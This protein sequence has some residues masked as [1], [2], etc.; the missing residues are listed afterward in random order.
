MIKERK[1]WQGIVA[2]LA[3]FALSIETSCSSFWSK[4]SI[5]THLWNV[6]NALSA[7]TQWALPAIVM[8][9]GSIFLASS[10][11]LGLRILWKSYIPF[12]TISAVL[13]WLATAVVW[14]QNNHPQELDFLT[15]R[16]CMSEVLDSPGNIGFCH[17]LVTFFILYPLL[18][19][20]AASRKLTIY[21]MVLFYAM[22]LIESVFKDIPYLSVLALFTDQLNWGYYRA[23][24]FY[25]LCGVW[26]TKY[27]H[28][29]KLC[30]SIYS[31]GILATGA[32]VALTSVATGFSPGY[33]NEYIGYSSPF[34]GLQ[35]VAVFLFIKRLCSNRHAPIFARLTR[36][37]WYCIPVLFVSSFFSD[38]LTA[39]FSGD[40]L[41]D[42]IATSM[43][44]AIIAALVMILFGFLPGFRIL[45]GDYSY[46]GGNTL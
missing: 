31:A 24:T 37:F 45:V 25:L 38:R 41:L 8:L 18:S 20:I 43:T 21:G 14:M 30:L 35:T 13:W 22:G 27:D 28:D 7:L 5:G 29:W 40:S 23:W 19:R 3:I 46:R 36:N 6:C 26:I 10:K 32:I 4:L 11:R 2:L 39:Y 1:A 17:M 9:V 12:A 33:A 34:T 42:V 15:F 16:E 44:N